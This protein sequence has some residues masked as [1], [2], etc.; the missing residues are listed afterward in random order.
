M[1]IRPPNGAEETT[2]VRLGVGDVPP[3]Y[4]RTVFV[5]PYTGEVRGR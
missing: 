5:D 1:A 4:A 2:Q 3:D